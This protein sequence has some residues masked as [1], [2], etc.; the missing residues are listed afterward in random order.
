M[1]QNNTA[2]TGVKL[3]ECY[4]FML[5]SVC[6][7]KPV[8]VSTFLPFCPVSFWSQLVY[9]C[10][11]VETRFYLS[12]TGV[13]TLQSRQRL[14]TN[15]LREDQNETNFS[16]SSLSDAVKTFFHRRFIGADRRLIGDFPPSPWFSSHLLVLL[17][18]GV[19]GKV[20]LIRHK[21]YKIQKSKNPMV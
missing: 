12:G 9:G 6:S 13:A 4:I 7:E 19:C 20:T 1:F 15:P 14:V 18:I 16:T 21:T 2:R 5:W 8:F 17:N 3:Y 10:G 11:R